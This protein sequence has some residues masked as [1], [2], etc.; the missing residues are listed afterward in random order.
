[1][2]D[3]QL[4]ELYARAIANR[5]QRGGSCDV[6][7]E[8]MVAVLEHSGN[9]AERMETLRRVLANPACREEFELLRAVAE[10]AR[11]APARRLNPAWSLAAAVA[12]LLGSGWLW[13]STRPGIDAL[14]GGPEEVEQPRPGDRDDP[15]ATPTD[16]A[17]VLVEPA[18]DAR[19][20][21]TVRFVWQAVPGARAYRVELLSEPGTL[22]TS[23]ETS[24]TTARY[25]PTAGAAVG[26]AYRWV[27]IALLPEG[28]EVPSR[29]RRLTITAP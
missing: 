16:A 20:A 26:R 15:G 28:V 18:A 25:A 19:V 3:E 13:W 8:A 4:K 22:V 12:L 14:R 29:P 17:P 10:G 6:P 2:N 5:A 11:E 24:D 27:V 21:R 23:I 1:M 7:L 9:E